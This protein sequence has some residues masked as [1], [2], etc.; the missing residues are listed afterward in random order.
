MKE[1]ILFLVTFILTYL[2]Y[3]IFVICR[4]NVLQK[5]PKGKEMTYFKIKYGIKVNEKNL[6]KIANIVFLANSFI[7]SSTVCLI[8]QFDNLFL[9]ILIGIITLLILILVIYHLVGIYLKKQQGG[10]KNV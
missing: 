1:L 8:S 4:K 7:L 6:K 2:F 3:V 9:K 5:F 10:K